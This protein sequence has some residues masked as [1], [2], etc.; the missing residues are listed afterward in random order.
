MVDGISDHVHQRVLEFFEQML[1]CGE[2]SALYIESYFLTL[3][4][5][6]IAN[7]AWEQGENRRERQEAYV[8]DCP[9]HFIRNETKATKFFIARSL[10]SVKQTPKACQPAG[11]N[12]MP[13]RRQVRGA[14][15]GGGE[16]DFGRRQTPTN[17]HRGSI[18]RTVR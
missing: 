16:Q 14:P 17:W 3:L 10:K 7:E 4:V 12:F 6:K 5:A 15:A 8:S 13:E 1:V 9:D 2:G 18:L 11:V